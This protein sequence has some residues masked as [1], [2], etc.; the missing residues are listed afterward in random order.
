L[1]RSVWA[2]VVIAVVVLA[3]TALLVNAA[4][5]RSATTQPVSLTLKS[6]KLW[7]FVD[8][9][10]GV[11]GPN[12][13]HITAEPTGGGL[14]TVQDIQVQLVKSGADLPPFTV[15]IR[16]LGPGHYYAPL[17]AIPYPGAW[18]MI[19]RVQVSA[20]DEVVL[21]GRFSLR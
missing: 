12:D 2:E 14:T 9:A 5:A 13:I 8:V 7:V 11:A 1:R 15:P 10:P 6:A 4:P 21:Q 20:T 3:I 19:V 17:Y 18:Q 16:K